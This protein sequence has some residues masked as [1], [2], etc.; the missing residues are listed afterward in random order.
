MATAVQ[1]VATILEAVYDKPSVPNNK[2]VDFAE[3]W[4]DMV[5]DGAGDDDIAEEFLI[6]IERIFTNGLLTGATK[7]AQR[8]AKAQVNAA[9]QAALA[10]LP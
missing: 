5:E 2:A 7:R 1:R 9:A 4:N 3:E 10:K 6:R 8:G